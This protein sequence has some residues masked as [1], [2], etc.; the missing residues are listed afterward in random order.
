MNFQEKISGY[1]I[2]NPSPKLI[3]PEPGSIL[4]SISIIVRTSKKNDEELFFIKRAKRQGDNFS[5]HM[6]FPGGVKEKY[7]KS[8]LDTAKRETMEEVGIDLNKDAE[9]VGRYDDYRPVNPNANAF[10]VSPHVF[11]LKK[12]SPKLMLNKDEVED[13]VWIP[14]NVIRDMLADS[15][16]ISERYDRKYNDNVFE[17]KG[18]KIWGMTGKILYSFINKI[19]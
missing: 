16:R 10:L 7:D 15:P 2:K 11:F 14:I 1:F 5:G 9:Y 6:A 13:T 17:Y 18:Y 3:E 4:S 12:S 8:I 19:L